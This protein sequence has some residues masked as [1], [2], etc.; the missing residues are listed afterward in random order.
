MK[1]TRRPPRKRFAR[2]DLTREYTREGP[3]L[4]GRYQQ[5]LLYGGALLLSA[6]IAFAV[7][8]TLDA[9]IDAFISGRRHVFFAQ[10][11]AVDNE[12]GR[13]SARLRHFIAMQG[14]NRAR[15]PVGD[16]H[17]ALNRRYRD[18]LANGHGFG[19]IDDPAFAAPVSIVSDLPAQT[20]ALGDS[21]RLLRDFSPELTQPADTD[22]SPDSFMYDDARTVLALHPARPGPP[23]AAPEL[24]DSARECIRRYTDTIEKA[25]S[26]VSVHKLKKH[27]IVWLPLE[28]DPLSGKL[29][30]RYAGAIYRG[31][32]RL[33]V[34]GAMRTIEHFSD[35]FAIEHAS[36]S[37]FFVM[38]RD[39]K[40]AIP[41][42][43]ATPIDEKY[44]KLILDHPADFE[45]VDG[46]LK[47]VKRDGTFF[48]VQR[49]AGP[50]WLA[51]YAF[52][53]HTIIHTLRREI[54]LTLSLLAGILTVLWC[55]VV[56]F[57]KR[58]FK[59]MHAR[60]LRV[61]ESEQLNRSVVSIAPVGLSVIDPASGRVILQNQIAKSLLAGLPGLDPRHHPLLEAA[62]DALAA[63]HRHDGA[64][65][66]IRE[67]AV[68]DADGAT[69]HLAVAF[70]SA[71]Y[72]NRDVVVCGISDISERKETE[73][74]L[75]EAKQAADDANNAKSLFLAS[76]SHEI[77]TPLHG[78]LGNLELLERT[79]LNA[80]QVAR[81]ATIR[82][83]FDALL[84]LINN[85]LD[86]S[87]I[88]AQA[89][90]L[91]TARFDLVGMLEN[92]ACTF[93]PL[94]IRKSV[95]FF[96]VIDPAL[97][98]YLIGDQ[99]RVRQILMNLLGNA[100]KFTSIGRILIHATHVPTDG[101]RY[102]IR[103]QIVDTGIGI[104][105]ESRQ[106]I[107]LP[108]TQADP[109]I[110]QRYGGTGLGLSLCK[111]LCDLMD[112]Q[113]SLVSEEGLGSH[114]SIDLPFDVA[115]QTEDAGATPLAGRS[116]L[117][118]CDAVPWR[119]ALTRQIEQWGA[120][121]VAVDSLAE[122][123]ADEQSRPT[124]LVIACSQA[125]DDEARL[126]ALAAPFEH[127]IVVSALAPLEPE[128][129]NGSTWVSSFSRDALLRA[130]LYGTARPATQP[131]GVTPARRGLAGSP[132]R[133][134]SILIVEDD[135]VARRLLDHQLSEIGYE[136]VDI[137]TNG[138]QAMHKC[139]SGR[140]DL[141]LTD[142]SMPHVD[143]LT[144]ARHLRGAGNGTP[145]VMITAGA[146]DTEAEEAHLEENVVAVLH[147]PLS[148]GDLRRT[149]DEVLDG[150]GRTGDVPEQSPRDDTHTARDPAIER[151]LRDLF[152]RSWEEA[153][154]ALRSALLA[155]DRDMFLRK[156]H[157]LKSGLAVLEDAPLMKLCVAVE[158]TVRHDGG[159]R[160]LALYAQFEKTMD[161]AIARHLDT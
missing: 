18:V 122:I 145:V 65:G 151:T 70:E 84:A 31:D 13:E 129:R 56:A 41:L 131:G 123:D 146:L 116:V 63:D 40:Q 67:I 57:D 60:S 11:E 106:K 61:H 69:R 139:A 143:G 45:H 27:Q 35:A 144:L 111:R 34:V 24:N 73:R 71:R 81:I 9:R 4:A 154:P 149:L 1:L 148:I 150:R 109:T 14:A 112:G 75:M 119:D 33:A 105:R 155:D 133:P 66:T 50:E 22:T 62:H 138:R 85:I 52:D 6:V 80:G 115:A 126:R 92:C 114:F 103:F 127:G 124:T 140:Y 89:L 16:P 100:V 157:K 97:P 95:H 25:L 142:M 107:Y 36:I 141:I 68:R 93:A 102:W 10:K 72:H 58:I 83:S 108:F 19:T 17:D 47:L 55:L 136:N 77:R 117:V 86:L 78:A 87:K 74:H 15:G 128:T 130:I 94:A 90:T 59:P 96:C 23:C 104:S 156:T 137:A 8:V 152:A 38:S 158:N 29:V 125:E 21:L 28:P 120:H 98:R 79:S 26:T 2:H 5:R 49:V 147:K 121:V 161:D 82:Q 46:N 99:N 7:T 91:S 153:A 42:N 12:I 118:A 76:M 3:H 160:A 51:V 20:E 64:G 88:Q 101:S 48:F 30:I 44:V 113:M 110:S 37:N 132:I 32:D 43:R 54:T 159:E 53:W 134:T 135:A 39:L